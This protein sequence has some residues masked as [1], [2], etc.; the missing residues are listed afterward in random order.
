MKTAKALGFKKGDFVMSPLFPAIITGHANSATPEIEAWGSGDHEIGSC[1]AEEMLK[2]SPEA[3]IM[4]ASQYGFDGTAYCQA[5][6]KAIKESI[7][8]SPAFASAV[9]RAKA[10]A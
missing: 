9:N 1:Y 6:K 5:A 4:L 8:K 2:V 10:A 3:F 7:L